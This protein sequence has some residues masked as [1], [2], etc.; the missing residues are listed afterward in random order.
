MNPP[1]A[2]A[3]RNARPSSRPGTPRRRR[4]PSLRRSFLLRR[5]ETSAR[6]ACG[7]YRSVA[8]RAPARCDGVEP[9]AEGGADSLSPSGELHKAF[10]GDFLGVVGVFQ[11]SPGGPKDHSAVP[12]DDLGKRDR[13]ALGE[14]QRL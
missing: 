14:P 7:V 2:M 10:L 5:I 6:A 3:S 13:V 8:G 11:D 12:Q 1:E 4:S 9:S